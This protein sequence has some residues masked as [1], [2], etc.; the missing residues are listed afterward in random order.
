MLYLYE[1][2][3]CAILCYAPFM[4]RRANGEGQI[5]KY[6]YKRITIPNGRRIHEHS[7]IVEQHIGRRLKKGEI[8]HHINGD[9]LDNRIQNLE[10]CTQSLHINKH[11]SQLINGRKTDGLKI[12]NWNWFKP[13]SYRLFYH[14]KK[15]C[16]IKHCKRNAVSWCLCRRHATAYQKWRVRNK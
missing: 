6:G 11:R 12:I 13:P 3:F 2:V 7:Y 4:K 10:L 16:L 1:V 15:L 8:I 5:T 9:R 14:K